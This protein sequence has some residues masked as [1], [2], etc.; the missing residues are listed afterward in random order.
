MTEWIDDPGS[1]ERALRELC[2]A[3]LVAVDCESN[4]MHAHRARVCVVQLAV[5]E[6]D[7]SAERVVLVDTQRLGVEALRDLLSAQGP[8]KVFHDFGY[9]ARIL[10]AEGVVI[11]NAVD[12]AVYARM[13]SEPATGLAS[14]LAKRFGLSLNKRFQQYDW[15]TRPLRGDALS[16]LAGDVS[17]LG[18]LHAGLV[19]EAE[20]LDIVEEIACETAWSLQRALDDALDEARASR[21]YFA[22]IKGYRELR[23]VARAALREIA[24]AREKIAEA[25]DLP[26]GRVL[27]NAMALSLAK[28]RPLNHAALSIAVGAQHANAPWSEAWLR[29]IERGIASPNLS[30]EH[31][32]YYAREDA[33]SDRGERKERAAK[34]T[35]WRRDEAA[36]R[37]V[38]IQ[39]VLPGHCVEALAALTN[40][41]VEA[42]GALGG[43]GEARR[44][45]YG[46]ALIEALMAPPA[47]PARE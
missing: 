19:A 41:S 27:P 4:A 40:P 38:D 7:R 35:A 44:R 39:V 34:L 13:L 42:L 46:E 24:E 43:L 25:R 3:P 11:G 9:D 20:A 16:Y 26:F 36:R 33:P 14:L 32:G 10:A 12:T 8:K 2:D 31:R 17:D 45:R 6:P 1:L 18:R 30:D 23:G 37:G 29:A 22:R 28:E 5:A 15:A 47:P 21:P